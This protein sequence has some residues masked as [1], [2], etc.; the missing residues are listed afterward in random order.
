ML[1]LAIL[2]ITISAF[3]LIHISGWGYKSS[4]RKHKKPCKTVFI[5]KDGIVSCEEREL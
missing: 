5:Y 2:S 4:S 3:I 1:Q